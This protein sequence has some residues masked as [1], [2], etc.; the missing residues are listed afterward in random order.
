[1]S[2]IL[3]TSR[4]NENSDPI[5]SERP[6]NFTNFFRSP[7]EIEPNS[8]IAVESVKLERTGN[9]T[10]G[11]RDFFTHYFGSDPDELPEEDEYDNLL[12]F[13]R[14]IRLQRGTYNIRQYAQHIQDRLNTQY[15][16]PNIFGGHLVTIHTNSSGVELGIDMKYVDK[17]PATVDVSASLV[18]KPVFNIRNPWDF[19]NSDL[20]PKP[21]DKFT[22]TEASGK[23]A[24][25]GLP[26]DSLD[27]SSS[28]GILTGRPFGLNN[29]EYIVKDLGNC[30]TQPWII[31]LSRPQ[32]QYETYESETAAD[33]DKEIFNIDSDTQPYVNHDLAPLDADGNEQADHETGYEIFDYAVSLTEDDKIAI[34]HRVYNPDWETNVHQE[35]SY[36][37]ASGGSVQAD[38]G[39]QLTKAQFYASYDGFKMEGKGDNIRIYF[40]QKGKTVYDQVCGANLDATTNSS[41][42]PIRDTSYALYPMIHLGEGYCTVDTFDSNYTGASPNPDYKYPTYTSG[43]KG[44]YIAG[45]DMFSNEAVYSDVGFSGGRVQVPN[46][47]QL[48]S[49]DGDEVIAQV[50]SSNRVHRYPD[51]TPRTF[52]GV[53]SANGVD[54]KHLLTISKIDYDNNYF[55]IVKSQEFPNLA[56]RLGF[57]DRGDIAST[58]EDYAAGDDTLTVTFT[59]TGELMKTGISSFI[60]LP[61]L[62]HKSFNGGQSGLSKILYQVPQFSNDGRQFGPLFFA[63]GEKTYVS[64]NNP[65]KTLL[66]SLQVQIVDSQEKELNSL[67]GTTQVV[68][69]IRKQR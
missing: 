42:V 6:A 21:S 7:I 39:T 26:A 40:K 47:R 43:A 60:R 41:P 3:A 28:V 29:G 53:N 52:H 54:Y 12:G 9:I 51:A 25:T 33:I 35:I 14:T 59:S 18:A 2:L 19:Y 63:P 45:S 49:S 22:Y 24:R 13:A 65:G 64:L 23:F 15:A 11:N 1:M 10:V 67:T 48:A 38:P 32:I 17:G 44:G 37:T 27:N 4:L 36:W 57:E 5:D 58:H 62:T 56:A 46:D 16:H 8:E 31:G 66:N 20:T 55:T 34:Y 69:H 30:S 50:D 68:F 61:G